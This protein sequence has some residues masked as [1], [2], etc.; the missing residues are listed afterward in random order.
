MIMVAFLLWTTVSKAWLAGGVPALSVLGTGLDIILCSVTLTIVAFLF[1]VTC[2]EFGSMDW[3]ASGG[4]GDSLD[5]EEC[6]WVS[7]AGK[8]AD[9]LTFLEEMVMEEKPAL[10]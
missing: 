1:T 5:W 7:D 10:F 6:L 9:L 3:W 2:L 8:L 4:E